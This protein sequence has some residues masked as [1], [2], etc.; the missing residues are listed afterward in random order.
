MEYTSLKGA[1]KTY[2]SEE[3]KSY[4]YDFLKEDSSL[5][6]FMLDGV[7]ADEVLD[8]IKKLHLIK[9]HEK[10]KNDPFWIGA[11]L[12]IFGARRYYQQILTT[13]DFINPPTSKAQE[14]S[15]PGESW[16]Q[17]CKQMI[18]KG[19]K[20]TSLHKLP[21]HIKNIPAVREFYM[22]NGLLDQEESE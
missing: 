4:Y 20:P 1:I 10:F 7:G 14:P 15:F 16:I 2:L 9:G 8:V 19:G 22:E 6:S 21:D 3:G 17:H 12:N 18:A 5:N 11:P 13:H